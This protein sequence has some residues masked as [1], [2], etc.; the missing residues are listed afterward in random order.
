VVYIALPVENNNA[1]RAIQQTH[2][3]CDWLLQ[4]H[5]RNFAQKVLP[6]YLHISPEICLPI[7]P[8]L[9]SLGTLNYQ[10]DLA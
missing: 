10:P 8:K 6:R 2:F 9:M 3:L 1:L 4:Y 5:T 7:A